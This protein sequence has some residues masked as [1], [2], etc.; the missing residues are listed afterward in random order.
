MKSKLLK[1]FLGYASVLLFSTSLV[2]AREA[3][4]KLKSLALAGDTSA[5]VVLG[6][7]FHHGDGET[8]SYTEAA[9]WYRMAAV[10]RDFDGAYGMGT[11]YVNQKDYVAAYSW[12]AL[13]A[14]DEEGLR[15]ARD[16]VY[17]LLSATKKTEALDAA[18]K[19]KDTIA[20]E[21]AGMLLK[22][23]EKAK[24]SATH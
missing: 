9:R 17:S 11:V 23:I 14:S 19:L 5:M 3:T 15:A 16:D 13:Y 6:G 18:K 21:Q 10:K 20:K 12:F 1:R 8:Q 4:E 24:N 22:A 7:R 2:F